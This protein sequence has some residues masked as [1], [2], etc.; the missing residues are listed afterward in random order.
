MP[1]KKDKKADAS[2][3]V[4]PADDTAKAAL[5][6]LSLQ[7]K[8]RSASERLVALEAEHKKVVAQ[9]AAQ[10]AD[11]KEIFEYLNLQ[12]R[13]LSQQVRQARRES[14]RISA[15]FCADVLQVLAKDQAIRDTEDRTQ[16]RE[17]ELEKK[18]QEQQE[19][20]RASMSTL[21]Q[22]IASYEEELL[23]LQS[24]QQKRMKLEQDLQEAKA[25]IE[26]ER[27]RHKN[28]LQVSQRARA[29]ESQGVLL[30]SAWRNA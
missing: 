5:E 23:A 14:T 19:A 12:M 13:T 9:L 20:Q 29:L 2:D 28:A 11:Q 16:K 8:L 27:L 30:S 24:F 26:N 22:Q 15:S 18:L 3:T 6:I 7:E 10:K 4:S 1:P 21:Q 25:F 17:L